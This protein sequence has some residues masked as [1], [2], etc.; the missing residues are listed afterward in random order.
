MEYFV[1]FFIICLSLSLAK[2]PIY[3]PYTKH[4]KKSH[5]LATVGV[6]E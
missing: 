5:L 3:C 1:V 6:F 2:G 4:I